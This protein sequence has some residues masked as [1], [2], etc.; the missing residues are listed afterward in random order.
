MIVQIPTK[1]YIDKYKDC[2][3]DHLDNWPIISESKV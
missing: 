1:N 3:G 2:G